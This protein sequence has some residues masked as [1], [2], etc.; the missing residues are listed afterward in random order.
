MEQAA[1]H[2]QAGSWARQLSLLA[3]S[4]LLCPST[5]CTHPQCAVAAVIA[6]MFLSLR[7][8]TSGPG[9]MNDDSLYACTLCSVWR[10]LGPL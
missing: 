5:N 1:P 10:V 3:Q 6:Y 7:Q 2:R 8:S 9:L 4:P